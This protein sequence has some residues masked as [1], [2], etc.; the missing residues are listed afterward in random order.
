MQSQSINKIIIDIDGNSYSDQFT[1]TLA[2]GS[3]V[4]KISAFL[5]LSLVL[6]KPWVHYLPVKMDLSDLKE[7]IE[8]A[9]TH[10]EEL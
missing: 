7:K 5:D 9:R 6:A 3:A 8:W 4:I 2:T 1:K 10:D